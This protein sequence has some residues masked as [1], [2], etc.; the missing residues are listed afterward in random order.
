M[1]KYIALALLALL[2]GLGVIV[3]LQ[4]LPDVRRYLR[5]RSM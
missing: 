3:I 5:L 2:A 4:I 1:L